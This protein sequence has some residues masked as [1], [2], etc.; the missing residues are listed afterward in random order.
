MSAS[1]LEIAGG[2]P[3]DIDDKGYLL[4]WH[5]WTPAVAETMA[6]A[7]TIVLEGDHWLVLR[8][9]QRLLRT[10]RNRTAHAGIGASGARGAGR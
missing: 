8:H 9:L 1:V 3:V 2:V 6:A 10:V 4:D 7:D 5:A